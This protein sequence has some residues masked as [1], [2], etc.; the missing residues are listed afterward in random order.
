MKKP[1]VFFLAASALVLSQTVCGQR[2]FFEKYNNEIRK[3]DESRSVNWLSYWYHEIIN[4][5]IYYYYEFL[6]YFGVLQEIPEQVILRFA[7]TQSPA[8]YLTKPPTTV[9]SDDLK[10]SGTFNMDS[11]IGSNGAQMN[12]QNG[13]SNGKRCLFFIYTFILHTS[14]SSCT[15]YFTYTL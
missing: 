9:G 15:S 14:P 7:S 2:I 12:F 4:D 13:E 11:I 1:M 8:T 3:L 10:A 6:N 5:V